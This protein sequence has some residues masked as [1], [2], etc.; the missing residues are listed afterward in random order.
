MT[1][2][3]GN[4]HGH[5]AMTAKIF[6]HDAHTTQEPMIEQTGGNDPNSQNLFAH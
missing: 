3:V 1:A 2:R 5:M 4:Q 6:N